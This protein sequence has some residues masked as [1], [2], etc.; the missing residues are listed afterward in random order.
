LVE[1]RLDEQSQRYQMQLKM[2]EAEMQ[3][4]DGQIDSNIQMTYAR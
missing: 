1:K 3:T 4:L 2:I